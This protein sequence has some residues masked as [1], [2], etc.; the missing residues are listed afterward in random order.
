MIPFEHQTNRYA[1]RF[2]AMASEGRKAFIPFTLLGWP[3]PDVSMAVVKQMIDS[4]ATALELGIPFSDPVAD[5]PV[6]QEAAAEAL[7]K[8]FRVDDAMTMLREI[9]FMDE[10]IPIGL[11][12]YY[13]LILARGIERFFGELAEVGVDAVLIPDL[14]PEAAGEVFPAAQRNGVEL[15]FIVSPLTSD[16]RL[17][18]IAQYAGGF[19]YVVSRLGITGVEERY[20]EELEALLTRIRSHAQLPLCIGFGIS[21]PHHAEKM[22]SIGADGVIVGSRIIQLVKQAHQSHGGNEPSAIA[23]YMAEMIKACTP[24]LVN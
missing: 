20:D 17:S 19:L 10:E 16:E 14:P 6:I 21:Q 22:F 15:I 11:L 24:N 23:A 8:G 5:G 4:G 1:R 12:V 18:L 3:T 2:K 9:R 13:N 7:L